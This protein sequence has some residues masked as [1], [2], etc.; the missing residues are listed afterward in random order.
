[1]VILVDGLELLVLTLPGEMNVQLDGTRAHIMA[2]VSVDHRVT[3]LDV[4]LYCSP[5][6]QQVTRKF[7]E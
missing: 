3:M 1:M 7:V 6:K 2:S 5:L 4:I